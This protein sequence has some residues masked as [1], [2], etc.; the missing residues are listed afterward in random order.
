MSHDE[1]LQTEEIEIEPDL[2]YLSHRDWNELFL[3]SGQDLHNLEA[4]LLR[5]HHGRSITASRRST[6]KQRQKDL[7]GREK[8]KD[9]VNNAFTPTIPEFRKNFNSV[10]KKIR[11]ENYDFLDIRLNTLKDPYTLM[12]FELPEGKKLLQEIQLPSPSRRLE[13]TLGSGGVKVKDLYLTAGSLIQDLRD[14]S[15]YDDSSFLIKEATPQFLHE[16]ISNEL[17]F[18]D[19]PITQITSLYSIGCIYEYIP[20]KNSWWGLHK[21]MDDYLSENYGVKESEYPWP[22]LEFLEHEGRTHLYAIIM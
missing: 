5:A 6:I 11:S 14:Y 2:E 16:I 18:G 7:G 8:L 17:D 20:S 10:L 19:S 13:L 12:F 21:V 22:E 9:I 1:A 15:F 4:A 3:L